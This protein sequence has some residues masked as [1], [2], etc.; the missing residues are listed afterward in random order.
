MRNIIFIL[1]DCLRADAVSGEDRG[2][3]TPTIDRLMAGGTYFSQAIS[4]AGTTTTCVASLLTGSYPFAHGVRTLSGYK[5]NNES[6]TL[7][8][9]LGEQGYNTYALV[10]GP[11]SPLTGLD[12]GFDEYHYRTENVYL[13]D[14]WGEDLKRMFRKKAFREPWFIFLHLWEVHRPRKVQESFNSRRYG[15]DPYE[16]SVSSLDPELGR[17]LDVVGEDTVTILHGDHGENREVA[18]RTFSLASI[19]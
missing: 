1:V 19:A 5:L 15:A 12:R 3:V 8:Q 17:L 10:T 9:I 4:T 13:S 14:Q 7:P 16:R 2:T 11:L 6:V 18:R